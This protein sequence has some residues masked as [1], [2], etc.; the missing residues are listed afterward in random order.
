M[1]RES[2]YLSRSPVIGRNNDHSH[3]LPTVPY[4]DKSLFVAKAELI[5]LLIYYSPFCAGFHF[6]ATSRR[7][8]A[9]S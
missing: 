1:P 7:Y 5:D 3:F 4:G 8:F 2:R 6:Y 9:F